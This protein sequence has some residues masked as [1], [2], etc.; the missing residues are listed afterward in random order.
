[1][2]CIYKS[3]LLPPTV[4]PCPDTAS[5]QF[6]L[7]DHWYLFI[8][9]LLPLLLLLLFH[10][11]TQHNCT[12]HHTTRCTPPFLPQSRSFGRFFLLYFFCSFYFVVVSRRPKAY[13]LALSPGSLCSFLYTS[14]FRQIF[15]NQLLVLFCFIFCKN[16]PQTLLFSL[17]LFFIISLVSDTKTP[18]MQSIFFVAAA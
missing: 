15:L 8:L 14:F 11:Y 4:L 7:L 1:M 18:Q 2:L 10:T 5:C 12:T 13:S 6:R 9:L 3:V 17:S 16:S